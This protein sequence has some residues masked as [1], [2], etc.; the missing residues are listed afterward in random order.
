MIARLASIGVALILLQGAL[1]Q[2]PK[3]EEASF[4]RDTKV[5]PTSG[6]LRPDAGILV[7]A[8]RNSYKAVTTLVNSAGGKY[9]FSAYNDKYI[10]AFVFAGRGKNTGLNEIELTKVT[11]HYLNNDGRLDSVNISVRV[12][13]V[14]SLLVPAPPNPK[15]ETSPWFVLT[16]N[17]NDLKGYNEATKFVL[18][19][20]RTTTSQ[21]RGFTPGRLLKSPLKLREEQEL[22]TG[23]SATEYTIDTAGVWNAVKYQPNGQK[24]DIGS[25]ML[26]AAE[27]EAVSE[28]IQVHWT[29]L[30]RTS[31]KG[32]T[33]GDHRYV[34]VLDDGRALAS[35]IGGRRTKT[36]KDNILEA[37]KDRPA[38]TAVY[39]QRFANVVGTIEAACK[40]E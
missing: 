33:G 5:N 29:H 26:S 24:S 37:A 9:N 23:V 15:S 40:P 18:V 8:D 4:P 38:A 14:K 12:R 13:E 17:R 1:A 16:F 35:N 34:L 31:P 10:L 19:E 20:E 27:M 2:A 32:Q 22:T 11:K 7:S 30:L 21:T 3:I 28:A 25:G 39:L 36:M 6:W